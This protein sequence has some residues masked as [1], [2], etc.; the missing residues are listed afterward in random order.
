MNKI[1]VIYIF[2]VGVLSTNLL[3]AQ[4]SNDKNLILEMSDNLEVIDSLSVVDSLETIDSLVYIPAA[5]V[6]SLLNG[7]DIFNEMPKA[8]LDGPASVNIYQDEELKQ[9]F[10]TY[11]VKNSSRTINGYRIR[12]YFDN[13]QSAR[14][15]SER[16][17]RIFI[18]KYHGISA[19][20]SYVNP[21]F[22]VTVGDFRSKSEA[23]QLLDELKNDF[24]SSFIVK[25][26]I[27][28]PALDKDK[29]FIVDTVKVVIPQNVELE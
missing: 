28:Y 11:I 1:I 9:A 26:D 24:P 2:L 12:I 4:N 21:Y 19:Y 29:T 25:E 5:L 6:D 3:V 8:Y 17:E 15:D 10:A 22:K 18:N 20:R 14:I 23:L 7:K 27:N 16:T 13:A